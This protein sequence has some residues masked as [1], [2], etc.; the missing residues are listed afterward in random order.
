VTRQDEAHRQGRFEQ[1]Y[2]E[3]RRDLLAYALRRTRSAEDA[4][5]VLAETYLITWRK[6]DSVPRGGEAR[7]W[8]FG[9]ARNV[10]RQ[11][12]TRQQALSATVEGLAQELRE[13][14]SAKPVSQDALAP[15]VQAALRALPEPQREVLLLTA[16]ERLTPREIAVATRTPVNLVRVRLH[17]ARAQVKRALSDRPGSQAARCHRSEPQTRR[18]LD[19]S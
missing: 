10:L 19:T 12:A 1:L 18:A 9:V 8:L 4:A 16:W 14:E 6:L 13:Q 11:G 15:C 5:D 2:R 3:T 17:R 7:L